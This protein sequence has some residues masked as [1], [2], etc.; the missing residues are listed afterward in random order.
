[1]PSGRSRVWSQ[2]GFSQ[3][4]VDRQVI[5]VLGV[6]LERGIVEPPT[7]SGP[8]L[9]GNNQIELGSVTMRQARQEGG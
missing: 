3:I 8:P 9:A 2:F 4:P 6:Q 5:P 7:N 1:M